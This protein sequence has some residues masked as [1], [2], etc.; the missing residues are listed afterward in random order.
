MGTIV[1]VLSSNWIG[2]FSGHKQDVALE[3]F[4]I[5]SGRLGWIYFEAAV[6][7]CSNCV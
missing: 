4:E 2:S 1:G 7:M 5:P 6:G 3:C